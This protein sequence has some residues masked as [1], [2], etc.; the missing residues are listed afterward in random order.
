MRPCSSVSRSRGRRAFP[1]P[2]SQLRPRDRGREGCGGV[3]DVDRNALRD[4]RHVALWSPPV[5]FA[6]IDRDLSDSTKEEPRWPK[7]FDQ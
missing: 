3:G 5:Q 7:A 4:Y 2:R 1:G 6:G